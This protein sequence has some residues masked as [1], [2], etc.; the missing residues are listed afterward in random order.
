[1]QSDAQVDHGGYNYGQTDKHAGRQMY[2]L[3]AEG[4]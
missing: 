2:N 4:I 1:M 3:I